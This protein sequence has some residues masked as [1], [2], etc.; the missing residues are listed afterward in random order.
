MSIVDYI[1]IGLLIWG[2]ISG[3]RKGLVL[4]LA[5][6][7]G[8]FAGIWL[9][10]HGSEQAAGW[11]REEAGMTGR[12][13]KHLGFMLVF[14]LVYI[15]AYIGGKAL[16]GALNLMMLG[17]VNKLAGGVFGVAKMILV[18]SVLIHFAGISG[19]ID[20]GYPA[21]QSSDLYNSFSG[22]GEQLHQV[23]R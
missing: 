14:V 4:Q 7:A 16:S 6:I 3:F 23:L 5:L 12:W 2:F 19:W 10:L 17:I 8:I 20:T 9:A 15:L 21:F 1:I 22:I 11:L 18:S 13:V